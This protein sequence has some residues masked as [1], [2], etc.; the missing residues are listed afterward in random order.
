MQVQRAGVGTGGAGAS[1][2]RR[3]QQETG[4]NE[5]ADRILPEVASA[6]IV[7]RAGL[8]VVGGHGGGLWVLRVSPG[9]EEWTHD[10]TVGSAK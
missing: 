1:A 2:L 7:G 3:V 9:G 8:V 10:G 6:G 5:Y 4:G